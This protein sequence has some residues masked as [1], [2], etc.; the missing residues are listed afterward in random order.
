MVDMEP[1]REAIFGAPAKED[2]PTTYPTTDADS[3]TVGTALRESPANVASP[4]RDSDPHP[5][6]YKPSHHTTP[7]SQTCCTGPVSAY[8]DMGGHGR[9]WAGLCTRHVPKKE[10]HA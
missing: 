1:L 8:A 7:Q 6:D 4:P 3:L 10:S 2:V 5:P 9:V